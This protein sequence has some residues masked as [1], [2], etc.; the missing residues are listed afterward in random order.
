MLREHEAQRRGPTDRPIDPHDDWDDW[1]EH[2]T[3]V[4]TLAHGL[5]FE[6]S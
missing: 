5:G 3:S 4:P 6:R 1:K 2:V